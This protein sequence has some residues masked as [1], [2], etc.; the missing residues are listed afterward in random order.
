M[1]N[2]SNRKTNNLFLRNSAFILLLIIS[3][4]SFGQSGPSFS[5]EN[6]NNNIQIKTDVQTN[7]NGSVSVS[8][9]IWYAPD[10]SILKSIRYY[11]EQALPPYLASV[12]HR[13]YTDKKI[14]GVT[15]ESSET[16]INYYIILEDDN[17]WYHVKCD[18]NGYLTLEKKYRKA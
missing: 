5:F 11:D 4:S 1:K 6:E 17:L 2:S 7:T 14:Y 15:E 16:G 10:H 13:R 8:A 9:K 3:V 12:V 18:A